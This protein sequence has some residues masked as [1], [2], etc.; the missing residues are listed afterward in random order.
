MYSVIIIEDEF[1]TLRGIIEIFPWTKHNMKVVQTFTD[2]TAALD[3]IVQNQ[4]DIVITD[5]EMPDTNGIMLIKKLRERKVRSK[6]L[7]LSAHSNFSYAQ[8]LIKLGIFEYCLKP[9]HRKD[10][11]LVLKR[12]KFS[13]DSKSDIVMEA[14]LVESQSANSRFSKIVQYINDHFSEKL[15]LNELCSSFNL[16]PDYCN[17]LFQKRFGCSYS[18]YL[19]KVRMEKACYLLRQNISI[20]DVAV[21]TGY[22]D[23][24]YFNKVFKS[25][26]GI[27][28]Y[29]YKNNN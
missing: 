4:P 26:F 10:A 20:A 19:K 28:P 7:V 15:T 2:S 17:K 6:I 25:Y 21:Q 13:L 16:N 1:W 11:D 3:Y 22:S 27:T 8:E 29:Q 12:L 9:I 5:I 14:D 18:S 24:Y 23:Y